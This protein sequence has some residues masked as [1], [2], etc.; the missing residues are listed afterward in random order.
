MKQLL[1]PLLLVSAGCAAEQAAISKTTGTVA[2]ESQVWDGSW[3]LEAVQCFFGSTTPVAT[4]TPDAGATMVINASAVSRVYADSDCTL[5]E[6]SSVTYSG[7]STNGSGETG[8]NYSLLN[9]T[10]AGGCTAR[11]NLPG[12]TINPSYY[13]MSGSGSQSDIVASHLMYFGSK[14]YLRK[15]GLSG[16]GATNCYEVYKR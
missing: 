15:S 11:L 6:T 13:Q 1:L 10:Y 12:G 16:G 2:T 8:G 7:L 4:E 14:L 3:T 9:R 5:T